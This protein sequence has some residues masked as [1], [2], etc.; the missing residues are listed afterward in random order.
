MQSCTDL[1]KWGHRGRC[2]GMASDGR[3][4]LVGP[5][6]GT[7]CRVYV[8]HS[9]QFEVWSSAGTRYGMEASLAK[10]IQLYE[11]VKDG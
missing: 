11:H 6:G 10:A 5:G 1:S 8:N 7:I 3:L 2:R 9:W 4:L